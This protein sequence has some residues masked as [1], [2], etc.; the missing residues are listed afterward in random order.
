MQ[1]NVEPST[2]APCPYHE[3][4]SRRGNGGAV[5][6]ARNAL[7]CN[8]NFDV[9][10]DWNLQP[11]IV[12]RRVGPD[13]GGRAVLDVTDIKAGEVNAVYPPIELLRRPTRNVQPELP[14][15]H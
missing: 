15:A 5:G 13:F 11:I 14:T 8:G 3:P 6:T 4:T 1:R 12:A 2:A 10:L 9:L 7:A